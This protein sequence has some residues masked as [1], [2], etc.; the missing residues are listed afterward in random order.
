M[1]QRSRPTLNEVA[2]AAGV[3]QSVV[4]RA[5]LLAGL[6]RDLRSSHNP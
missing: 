1:P 6:R 3:S 4:S 2:L 5:E